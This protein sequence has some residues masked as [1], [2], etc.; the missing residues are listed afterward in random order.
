M[1]QIWRNGPSNQDDTKWFKNLVSQYRPF[2]SFSRGRSIFG[3]MIDKILFPKIMAL[4]TPLHV[5]YK[6]DEGDDG[7]DGDG[8]DESNDG[9]DCVE[10]DCSPGYL[11]PAEGSKK[12]RLSDPTV[13][14]LRLHHT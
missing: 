2:G 11:V 4:L 8:D 14:H 7:D 6:D 13:K 3:Q 9:D 1:A 10:D 5:S 12:T